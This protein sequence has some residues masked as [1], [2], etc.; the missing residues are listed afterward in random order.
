LSVGRAVYFVVLPRHVYIH[1]PFCARRCTYCDFSIAVRRVV[2]VEEYTTALD[3]ELDLRFSDHGTW[4]V[5]TL[6]FGGGTPSRL[7]ADGVRRMLDVVRGRV[8]LAPKAEVTLEANPE[9]VTPDSVHAWR[10]SGVNRLSIGAQSFHDNVLTWM[11][12][13]HDTA[14]IRRA[15]ENAREGDIANLSLDLIFALPQHVARSWEADV[16]AALELDPAHLSLYGLTVEP[17]TPLGRSHARGELC[18]SPDERYES[19]FVH[20][21]E[22]LTS[23]GFEHYEVSNF[24]RA[25]LH[26]RHNSAYWTGAG[27]AGLGPSAHEFDGRTRR[28]NVAAYTEW[29][30]R[31]EAEQDPLDESEDLTSDNRLA[32]EVYL[33]LRTR[34]GLSLIRSDE[35]RIRMWIDA[36]W[37]TR[38]STDRVVLTPHG[39]LRLD[40]LAA[41]LTHVRSY[42]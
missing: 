36:G 12:R 29:L 2:P 39:W 41:D 21:H 31:L 35:P 26:S 10:E 14:A 18:E 37:A 17:R 28:W 13:T 24:G 16:E 30:R 5:D 9:D 34:R 8:D 38:E 22:A 32:E 27:Y 4:E 3:R 42:Y 15:V 40:A 7:G 25:G 23:A 6:Y 19:E 33:G 20:A 1:V 11:H